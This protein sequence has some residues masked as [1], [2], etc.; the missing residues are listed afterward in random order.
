MHPILLVGAGKIGLAT[1][2][3]LAD[4]GD[5]DVLVADIDEAS[6]A[7]VSE[8]TSAKTVRLAADDL[9]ALR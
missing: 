9:D 7:R 6:L 8:T 2:S 4:T 1:A 3:L 5:Y